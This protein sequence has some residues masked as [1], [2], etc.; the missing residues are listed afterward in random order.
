MHVSEATG[1]YI[2]TFPT[3]T[4]LSR[5][6]TF[7]FWWTAYNW[8]TC[9]SISCALTGTAQLLVSLELL[10][11]NLPRGGQLAVINVFLP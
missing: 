6:N 7:T 9:C 11:G 1:E 3:C 10:E 5:S 2:Q 8:Y 4:L